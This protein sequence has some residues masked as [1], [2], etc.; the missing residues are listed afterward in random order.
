VKVPITMS[1]EKILSLSTILERWSKRMER[2]QLSLPSVS[3]LNLEPF[4][5]KAP[6]FAIIGKK[7]N[8]HGSTFF[9]IKAGPDH[10]I[11]RG[12]NVE[13]LSFAEVMHQSALDNIEITYQKCLDSKQPDIWE[14]A[15]STRNL[16]IIRYH[17]LLLPIKDDIGD[18]RCLLG[19]WFWDN[20][21]IYQYSA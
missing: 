11:Y 17:R 14:R 3:D 2:S 7:N 9:F 20:K 1:E 13:G 16:P 6:G 8:N 19:I 10:E 21:N 15:N 12:M 5:E 4:A 18:G